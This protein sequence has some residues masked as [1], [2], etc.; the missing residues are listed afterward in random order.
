MVIRYGIYEYTIV[1]FIYAIGL[2][3]FLIAGEKV[4]DIYRKINGEA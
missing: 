1:E 3:L 4:V 2:Y